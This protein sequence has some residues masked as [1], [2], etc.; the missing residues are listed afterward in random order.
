MFRAAV[1]LLLVRGIRGLRMSSRAPC[2]L[3]CQG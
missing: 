2:A 3:G 1:V